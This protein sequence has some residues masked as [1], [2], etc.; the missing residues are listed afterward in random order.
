MR[1][2]SILLVLFLFAGFLVELK[3][4]DPE[5]SLYWSTFG[6]ANTFPPY[7]FLGTT[8]GKPLIF[9]TNNST[10]MTISSSGNIGIGTDPLPSYSLA[11]CGH[12]RATEVVVETGWCD[13]VFE[14]DYSLLPLRE[15][16]AFVK[17]N[18]HLPG[19]P[20]G[21]EIE[22]NGVKLA[23]MSSR[24]ILKIEELTLYTIEQEK[25]IEAQEEQIAELQRLTEKLLKEVE[26]LKAEK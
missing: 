14:E 22:A 1:Y 17:K 7:S 13:F 2:L 23:D 18:K 6:N 20:K 21:S 3:A 25:K 9:K 10:R 15:V 24:F 5:S 16:E 11:I 8:D 19:I 12:V 26:A 4:Q